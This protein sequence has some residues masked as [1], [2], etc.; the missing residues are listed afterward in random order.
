MPFELTNAPSTFQCAM[1]KIFQPFL[2]KLVAV[3]FDDILVYSKGL[4]ENVNHLKVVLETLKDHT[5]FAKMSKCS[6]AQEN[7]EYIGHIVSK[8]GVQVDRRK[9][10][11]M[12]D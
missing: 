7:T 11:A 6:F 5:L 8:E 4:E 2:R 1:N 9:I 3:F 10:Q 12:L